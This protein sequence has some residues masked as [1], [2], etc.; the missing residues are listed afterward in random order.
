[1]KTIVIFRKW[2]NGDI[3]ALFPEV[4]HTRDG[5]DCVCFEHVGQHGQADYV[6]VV[7]LTDPATPAEYQALKK[8]L[9]SHPY[10]YDLDVRRRSSPKMTHTRRQQ[11]KV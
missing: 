1:M 3:I 2:H 8:E 11:A 7:A 6:G 10:H 5:Y 4:P 9:E